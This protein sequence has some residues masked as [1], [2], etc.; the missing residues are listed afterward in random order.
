[1]DGVPVAFLGRIYVKV[2]RENGDINVGDYLVPSSQPGIAMKAT[3]ASRVLGVALE[4]FTAQEESDGVK[5][6]I[7]F[8]N[9]HWIGN[10][11]FAIQNPEDQIVN[12]SVDQL[13]SSLLELG[14]AIKDDGTLEVK[15]VKSQRIITDEFETTDK[16]TGQTYCIWIEN[17]EWKKQ[18]G[19]CASLMPQ[20][21]STPSSGEVN[22]TSTQSVIGGENT[23]STQAATSTEPILPETQVEAEEGTSTVDSIQEEP[24]PE[25][26]AATQEAVPTNPDPDPAP[27]TGLSEPNAEPVE[28]NLP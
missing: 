3:K 9:P 17:G 8:V 26:E 15:Q 19:A 16:I 1:K 6:I 27:E 10:D 20:T 4:K 14:L 22:G 21:A 23:T 7:F 18:V 12:L 28:S 11:L 13:K 24:A 25:E 2:S 5:K